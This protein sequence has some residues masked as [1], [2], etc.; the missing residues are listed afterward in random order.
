MDLHSEKNLTFYLLQPPNW[1]MHPLYKAIR[2][3][4]GGSL[5]IGCWPSKGLGF[6]WNVDKDNFKMWNQ[7]R[8]TPTSLTCFPYFSVLRNVFWWIF[9]LLVNHPWQ[10][11]MFFSSA[12]KV[13]ILLQ[14]VVCIRSRSWAISERLGSQDGQTD[15]KFDRLVF[16]PKKNKFRYPDIPCIWAD[17]SDHSRPV[18]NSPKWWWK[19]REAWHKKRADEMVLPSTVTL[20]LYYP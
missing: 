2:E 3:A 15:L 11:E 13:S 4:C 19:V 5:Y 12:F 14:M 6:F 8:K 10:F 1:S 16:T 17:Y 20:K 18:G 7:N 9:Y